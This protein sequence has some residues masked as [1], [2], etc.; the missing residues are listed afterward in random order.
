MWQTYIRDLGVGALALG[1]RELQPLAVL[2]WAVLL[3]RALVLSLAPATLEVGVGFEAESAAV[4]HGPAL[5]QVNCGDKHSP[6]T[7]QLTQRGGSKKTQ[8]LR[9]H[10]SHREVAA[11]GERA[12]DC[13]CHR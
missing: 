10:S 11:R 1:A 13:S 4:T 2:G 3:E 9:H 7:S 6:E 8:H 12:L 5:V